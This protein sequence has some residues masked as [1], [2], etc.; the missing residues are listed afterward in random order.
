LGL[1]ILAIAVVPLTRRR[2]VSALGAAGLLAATGLFSTRAFARVHV[3]V[4]WTDVE[5][6]SGERSGAR[7]KTLRAILKKEARRADW[8]APSRDPVRA[9]VR[10][11]EFAVQRRTDVTRVTCTAVGKMEGGASVKTHFSFGG[12]PDQLESLE[13]TM[14]TLIGRGLVNRL[15]AVR[16]ER[17]RR[18]VAASAQ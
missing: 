12:R 14:L 13:T 1:P 3:R 11:T 4:E 15:A 9:A 6:P 16:R 8:G 17:H 7:E 2:L 10:V 5:L 18:A